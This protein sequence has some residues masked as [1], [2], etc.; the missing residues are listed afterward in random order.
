MPTSVALT[1][2]LENFTKKL[3]SSG[4]YNNVSEVVRE[5][6]RLMER[7]Q[8]QDE[9]KLS[10]LR[11]AIQVADNDVAAGRVVSFKSAKQFGQHLKN[12]RSKAALSKA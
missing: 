5:S 11:D 9:A 8:L 4:R 3:V 12:M 2:Y 6:L 1:P 10:A 7:Q